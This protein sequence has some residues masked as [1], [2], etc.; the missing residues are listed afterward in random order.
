MRLSTLERASEKL[1]PGAFRVLR[2]FEHLGVLARDGDEALV[3]RPHWLVRVAENLALEGLVAGPGFDWG[4]AL[5]SPRMATRT[6]ERLVKSARER[7]LPLDELVEPAA[8]RD[9][10]YAAAI[11]GAVRALGAAELSGVDAD[12]EALEPLWNEQLRL[13]VA[14]PDGTLHPRIEHAPAAGAEGAFWLTRGA[15]YLALLALGEA[16][17]GHQGRRDPLLRPWLSTE[18]PPGV[19]EM[20]DAVALSLERPDAPAEILGPA[21]GLVSRL[22]ALLGPL[23]SGRSRH[24]LERAATVA[25]EAAVG[26]LNWSSIAALAGDRLA[27]VGL[28]HLVRERRLEAG[29]LGRQVFQAFEA[30]GMPGAEAGALFE[31]ELAPLVLPSAPISAL[32]ALLAPLVRLA[33]LPELSPSQWHALLA[34]DL[35]AVPAAFF[36]HVPETLL[37]AA[38]DAACRAEHRAGIAVLWTRSSAAMTEALLR[39]LLAADATGTRGLLLDTAPPSVTPGVLVRLPDAPTLLK[40]PSQSLD[41]VR[42]FL[43]AR[44]T[45][46][47]PGFRDAYALFADL[48]GHLEAV[49]ARS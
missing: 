24:R 38:I 11:E 3:L 14:L 29:L 7:A 28:A 30:A 35:R 13:T 48:E 25:D 18:P 5:L 10:G 43:H 1:P 33:E 36:G 31:P 2:C 4:D 39:M 34:V 44:V 41:A 22:G 40:G 46:R 32:P 12:G 16:L 19:S 49:H 42:R 45:E 17:D 20:L 26:V 9:P 37:D 8:S 47:G 6:M 23:G 27:C 21:V 15:W